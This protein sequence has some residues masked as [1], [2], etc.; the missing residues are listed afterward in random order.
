[1]YVLIVILD[2]VWHVYLIVILLASLTVHSMQ[3]MKIMCLPCNTHTVLQAT[4]QN[5]QYSG[6]ILVTTSEKITMRFTYRS[7]WEL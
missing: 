1:M 4:T 3:Q 5:E 2:I 6:D 7:S